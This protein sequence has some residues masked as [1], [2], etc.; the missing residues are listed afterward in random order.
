MQMNVQVESLRRLSS[1]K[2]TLWDRHATSRPNE[3]DG[4]RGRLRD[5][6]KKRL[7]R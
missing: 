2:D 6:P 4:G 1:Y 7:R 3:K 5:K